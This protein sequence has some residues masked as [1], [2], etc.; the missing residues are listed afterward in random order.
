MLRRLWTWFGSRWQGWRNWRTGQWTL[1]YVEDPPEAV[2]KGRICVVGTEDDPY[3]IVMG[4]PCGCPNPIFLDLVPSRTAEHWKLS[5]DQ[6]GAPTLSPSVWRTDGCRSHF[7]L[8]A[9][10]VVWC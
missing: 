8:R 5:K 2:K 10:M 6:K 9:G 1:I 4:C 7:W 3:Q